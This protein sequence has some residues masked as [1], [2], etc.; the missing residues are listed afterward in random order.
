VKR[1]IFEFKGK[2]GVGLGMY[3]TYESIVNFA[4]Q[5]FNYALMRK[6]PLMLGTKNTILK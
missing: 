2:G 4:H 6:Y 3:N 1:T 5:S